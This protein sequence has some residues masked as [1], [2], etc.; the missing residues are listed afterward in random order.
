MRNHQAKRCA[1]LHLA[2]VCSAVLVG[3]RGAVAQEG[4]QFVCEIALGGYFAEGDFG[5]GQQSRIGY[6]PL[7]LALEKG[8]WRGQITTSTLAVEGAGNILVNL[9][10]VSRPVAVVASG[11]RRGA[12]DTLLELSYSLPQTTLAALSSD[13]FAARWGFSARLS[14]KLPTADVEAGLGTGELD[15]TLQ[16]DASVLVTNTLLFATLGYSRRGQSPLYPE[17]ISSGFAQLGAA[18]RLTAAVSVGALYDYQQTAS[19]DYSDSQE[20]SVYGS[21]DLAAN[22]SLTGLLAAGLN[23]AAADRAV[24][25][26]LAYRW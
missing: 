6:L 15:Q 16:L 1:V 11:W 3:M 14:T 21:W 13:A 25:L 19:R 23:E 2:L 7:S 24:Y 22:W 5:S 9:G 18:K 4:A 17:I 12:G 10:G 8:A 26:Q 20:L